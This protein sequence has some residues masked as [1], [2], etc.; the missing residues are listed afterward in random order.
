M[1]QSAP[2]ADLEELIR[3]AYDII[4]EYRHIHLETNRP[5][6]RERAARLIAQ[7]EEQLRKL[8]AQYIPHYGTAAPTDIAE[9][10]A[11][12]GTADA[13]SQSAAMESR[14]TAPR[15][16]TQSGAGNIQIGAARDVQINR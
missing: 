12:Y 15:S 1:N 8:L 7:K 3:T 6:E 4:R 5:E 2:R 16:Q 11:H 9:I 13:P 14:P 10:I